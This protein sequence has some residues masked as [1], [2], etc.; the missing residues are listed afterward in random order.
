MLVERIEDKWIAAFAR[1]LELCRIGQGDT[2]AILSETQSRRVN[3]ELAEL[4]ALRCGARAFHLMVP[5]PPQTAPVPVRSTGASD[6]VQRLG[7]VVKALAASTLVL[8]LTVEGMLH[9]REL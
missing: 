2:V 8:D 7:P 1:V 5:T 3:A 9:A 6:A 4:A